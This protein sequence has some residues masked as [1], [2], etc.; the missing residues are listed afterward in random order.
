MKSTWIVS[1]LLQVTLLQLLPLSGARSRFLRAPQ[2]V[3]SASVSN[4]RTLLTLPTA[5]QR[6]ETTQIHSYVQ[7]QQMPLSCSSRT[8]RCPLHGLR[9]RHTIMNSRPL[10][11]WDNVSLKFAVE[12]LVL[13]HTALTRSLAKNNKT[14]FLPFE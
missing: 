7:T 4:C 13:T 14:V 9:M 11:I 2:R 3:I 1:T 8:M 5:Q 6:K 12:I 10:Q